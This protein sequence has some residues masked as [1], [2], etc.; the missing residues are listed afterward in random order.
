MRRREQYCG[1]AWT[2]PRKQRQNTDQ[3]GHYPEQGWWKALWLHFECS[4]LANSE[5]G[6][7]PDLSCSTTEATWKAKFQNFSK[8]TEWRIFFH[9]FLKTVL[10]ALPFP[11]HN[12]TICFSSFLFFSLLAVLELQRCHCRMCTL[13][14]LWSYT[15]IDLMVHMDVTLFDI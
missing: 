12:L 11:T 6:F 3:S 2:T 15:L 13:R 9:F 8:M 7:N 10:A 5:V 14:Q 4:K 1:S